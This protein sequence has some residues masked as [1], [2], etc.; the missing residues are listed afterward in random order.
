VFGE[1]ILPI[2]DPL[3]EVFLRLLRMAIMPLIVTSIISGVVSVGNAAGLGRLSLRT[4]AYYVGSSLLAI[5]T[6]QILVNLL[7]P[8]VGAE[9]GLEAA[10]EHIAAQEQGI[11]ELLI[12]II[13]EN[14]FAALAQGDVLPV[15]FF[16]ILFGYFI[17]YSFPSCSGISSPGS[18]PSPGC[19]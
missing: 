7:K 6:G 5:L 1:G 12:R 2:A 9:I 19:S 13:P 10:P 4:F 8:G 18:I 15:I 16:S 11:G 3:A 14:P 17:T